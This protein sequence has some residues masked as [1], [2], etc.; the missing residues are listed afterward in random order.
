MSPPPHADCRKIDNSFRLFSAL[1]VP[2]THLAVL[3]VEIAVTLLCVRHLQRIEHQLQIGA[4][5]HKGQLTVSLAAA[6][7]EANLALL[8][9]PVAEAGVADLLDEGAA[10]LLEI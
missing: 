5:R 10:Q 1:S 2:H 3:L 8:L 4:G 7:L 9:R 6:V